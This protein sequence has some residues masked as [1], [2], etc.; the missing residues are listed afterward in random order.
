MEKLRL[1][2]IAL[3]NSKDLTA[4]TDINIIFEFISI[5]QGHI[6]FENHKI[7]LEALQQN[8]DELKHK[9]DSF[10]QKY[11]ILNP[12]INQINEYFKSLKDGEYFFIT[13][14]SK[15]DKTELYLYLSSLNNK[16]DFEKI[17]SEYLALFGDFRNEYSI[18]AFDGSK[19]YEIGE[20]IKQQRICRYCGKSMPDVSFKKV[21]HAVSEALGNKKIISCEECDSCNQK[22]GDGIEEDLILYLQLFRSFFG[23]QR[24]RGG[25]V[26]FKG[27]NF[28]IEKGS[29]GNIKLGYTIDKEIPTE[30]DLKAPMLFK[31]FEN[32][33]FQNIYKTLAKY[34]LGVIE[35]DKLKYFQDTISWINEERNITKLPKVAILTSYA[36]FEMHPK[37]IVYIRKT[38]NVNLP[39]CVCELHFVHLTFSAIIPLSSMDSKNFINNNDYDTFWRFFKHYQ[40]D[41]WIFYD[42]SNN[43]K[44]P[45]HMKIN[46]EIRDK[47]D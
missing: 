8:T 25:N 40:T 46:F 23:I 9:I 34:T 30:E 41:R 6:D 19:K 29:D 45:F 11:C 28:D 38:D 16:E 44:Q 21:A 7:E 5:F 4:E 43:K 18:Y 39:Y 31:T 22:F 36:F 12:V 47:E 42:F 26:H 3:S 2:F 35:R 15:T 10:V 33:N 14:I 17:K 13:S 24:K 20:K 37:I 1:S 27:E 32:I